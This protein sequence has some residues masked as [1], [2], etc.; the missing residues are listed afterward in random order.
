[1]QNIEWSLF[2]KSIIL[3]VIMFLLAMA[4]MV[5]GAHYLEDVDAQVAAMQQRIKSLRD[6]KRSQE[7]QL[8]LL[9]QY[10]PRFEIYHAKGVFDAQEPRIKWVENIREIERLLRLPKKVLFKLKMRAP[11]SPPFPI[12]RGTYKLFASAMTL[13]LELLHE[14]DLLRFFKLLAKHGYGVYDVRS[15]IMARTDNP[16]D[17]DDGLMVVPYVTATCEINWYTM[18]GPKKKGGAS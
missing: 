18:Q 17:H 1:M 10:K 12:Q 8:R 7:E 6:K 2:R 9:G 5:G 13:T 11:F 3:F 16:A 4:S 14:G 15:C